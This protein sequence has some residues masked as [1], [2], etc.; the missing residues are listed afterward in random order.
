MRPD[1]GDGLDRPTGVTLLALLAAVIGAIEV[2][3]GLA[4]IAHS[5]G[6][7]QLALVSAPSVILGVL[8]LVVG[9]GAL[10]FA[11]GAWVLRP[12][13]WMLGIVLWIVG[14]VLDVLAGG[15]WASVLITGLIVYYL[16][17]P[18]VRRSFGR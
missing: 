2:L 13:A 3:L 4:A 7:V 11:Y 14:G 15:G 9:T 8:T 12:W 5:P 10:I 1:R 16:C 18:H 17:R 6:T